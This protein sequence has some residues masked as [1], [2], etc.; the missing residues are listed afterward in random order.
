MWCIGSLFLDFEKLG[1]KDDDGRMDERMKTGDLED[2]FGKRM[3]KC[4]IAIRGFLIKS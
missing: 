1:R 2:L 3:C 4:G